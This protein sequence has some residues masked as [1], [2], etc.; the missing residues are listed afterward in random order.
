MDYSKTVNLPKTDFPMRANLVQR[1]PEM[2]KSWESENI[3]RKMSELHAG[4]PRFTLHDGPPYANGHIHLGTAF[5]KILK[6]IAVRSQMREGKQALFRPGWD[7]HGMPIEH[8]VMQKSG[9]KK[10]EVD[11][12][13]FR[14]EAAEYAKKFVEIQKKEFQ[15]LGV[16][17]E[18]NNPYLTL[19]PEYE[20]QEVRIFADLSLAG[21]IYRGKRPIYWCTHCET[22]LAEAEI[23]Y[24][25]LSTDSIYTL[26][27]LAGDPQKLLSGAENTFF[28][29]WTTTPWTLPAN[30]ALLVHPELNY[31]LVE[32][33]GRNI[34]LAENLIP[35]V[36]SKVGKKATLRQTNIKGKELTTLLAKHPFLE[37]NVPVIP[38]NFVS[39]EDGSGIVHSA[40]GHGEEDFLVGKEHNLPVLSPVNETGRFTADVPE[41]Q[42]IS[43][44]DAN[45]LIVQKLRDNNCLLF[46]EEISHSYPTCWRCKNPVIF[47]ATEQWF[48]NVD[49][50][51]LRRRMIKATEEIKFFPPESQHRMEGMLETRPDWCLSRQRHWGI[52]VPILFCRDCKKPLMEE[53]KV[54]ER[55]AEVFSREGSDSWF[56]KEANDF[57]PK[58]V[59]CACGSNRFEKEKDILDV[60]FDSGVSWAGV[61]EGAGSCPADLYLEG[62]DQHRGWFQ[63]SLI[64]SMA[65]REKAPF[66]QVLTHGFMVDES[67]RKM[68]KSL[69]NVISSEEVLKEFGADIVRLWAAGQD[70]GSDIKTSLH[71]FKV[72][73]EQY[74]TIRNTLRFILGNIS[75]FNPE[76]DAIKKEN[77]LPVDRWALAEVSRFQAEAFSGYQNFSFYR[78]AGQIYD[79]CNLTL[80]A[81]YLD[82]LKDRLYT[83]SKNSPERRSG[84]T[85]LYHIGELLIDLLAPILVFTAEEAWRYLPRRKSDPESIHLRGHENFQEFKDE[86]LTVAF[87]EFFGLRKEILKTIEDVRAQGEIG[88]SLEAKVDVKVNPELLLKLA[89]LLLE[90]YLKEL[91]IV[92][93]AEI[94][95]NPKSSEPEIIV[96]RT[97]LPKCPRC[98][99]HHNEIGR[100]SAYPDLCPKC[101]DA[102]SSLQNVM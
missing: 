70:Y 63:T 5:N 74:R 90:K 15:R 13:S 89:P 2:L 10:A 35:V 1:E 11:P 45:P 3:F 84:Q 95:A 46:S 99:V 59:S 53:R 77:L 54:F 36:F 61:L 81:F 92:S 98:W 49:H 102:V 69:G 87:N 4:G 96:N 17:G 86:T 50:Q 28:L 20:A 47:R 44:W 68:S 18:W 64:T 91:L 8:Q 65:T 85:A 7:C 88:S 51:D 57:V 55:I 67:G 39:A 72:V 58:D 75:D 60:W 33:E 66:R 62:S 42:G 21:Y 24:K 32:F 38:A 79:F 97:N 41:W 37:R 94:S 48:L 19:L 29:V 34:I 14:K 76:E 6:D 101:A 25:D 27:P 22:A 31:S 26:F 9:R 93:E 78:V 80:S 43:V 83:Y 16:Y 52:P 56:K 40:P 12:V 100:S 71:G 82:I 23:E 73:A 30:V